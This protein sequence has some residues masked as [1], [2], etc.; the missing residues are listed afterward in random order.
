M[1]EQSSPFLHRDSKRNRVLYHPAH[2]TYAERIIPSPEQQRAKIEQ[3]RYR[4]YQRNGTLGQMMQVLGDFG[5]EYGWIL[6]LLWAMYMWR[7]V[8]MWVRW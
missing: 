2:Q 5:R 3:F 7:Y 4:W 6:A 1:S 8:T